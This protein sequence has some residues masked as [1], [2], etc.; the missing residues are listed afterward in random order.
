MLSLS[1]LLGGLSGCATKKED[2]APKE[3]VVTKIKTVV[4]IPPDS[5]LRDCKIDSPPLAKDY[6]TKPYKV[7]EGLLTSFAAK[8]TVNLGEC[9]K[10]KA[11]LR[12]WK[13]EQLSNQ[14]TD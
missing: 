11:S 8:Q 13:Q 5:L 6:V 3:V 2:V 1:M 7:K 14:S 4:R 9:N 12:K 10:D